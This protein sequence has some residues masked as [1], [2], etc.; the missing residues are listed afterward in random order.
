MLTENGSSSE[1]SDV[2]FCEA[3]YKNIFL[4]PT[5]VEKFLYAQI[6]NHFY[7]N[8]FHLKPVIGSYKIDSQK[9][10]FIITVLYI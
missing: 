5:L 8:F 10:I 7:F 3:I 1:I 9:A 6:V 2:S 4:G